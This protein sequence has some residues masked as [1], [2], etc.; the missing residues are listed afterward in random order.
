MCV[1]VCVC[2]CVCVFRET[3]E[4][5]ASNSGKVGDRQ[6][7]RE[8]ERVRERVHSYDL[9]IHCTLEEGLALQCWT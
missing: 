8:R 6:K 9:Y 2:L 5:Q 3:V 1:C 4:R 7:D